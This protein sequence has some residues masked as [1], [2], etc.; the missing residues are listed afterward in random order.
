MMAGDVVRGKKRN[1]S[2]IQGYSGVAHCG[3]NWLQKQQ[4]L[5]TE[6][7]PPQKKY[8]SER[9]L[10]RTV[11]SPEEYELLRLSIE[12]KYEVDPRSS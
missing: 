5:A 2:P 7:G 6:P 3:K 9:R 8:Q 1:N 11:N 4:K 10:T 12:S